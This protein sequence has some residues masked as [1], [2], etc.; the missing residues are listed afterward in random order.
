MIEYKIS[1]LVI[2][3]DVIQVLFIPGWAL[4]QAL[5]LWYL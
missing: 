1:T 5:I 2:V 3:D 4:I